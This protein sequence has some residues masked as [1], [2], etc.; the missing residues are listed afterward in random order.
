M[1][2]LAF[3]YFCL[4]LVADPCE[5][6]AG[7]TLVQLDGFTMGTTWRVLYEDSAGRNF[8]S[9]I[10]SLFILLNRSFSTYD[11]ASE[12]SAFNRSD[13]SF[14]FRTPF[15]R[16]L[17]ERSKAIYEASAG[18][19]DPTVM[20]LVRAWGFGPDRLSPMRAPNVDSLLEFVGFD[21]ISF[22]SRQA[23]KRD[24]RVQLDFGGIGQGFAVDV[25]VKF[26]RSKG[27]TDM[28]VELGGEGV[29]MGRNISANRPWHVGVL[30]PRSTR[31]DQHVR[32]YLALGGKAFTTSGNYFNYRDVGGKRVGHTMDPKTGFPVQDR[33]LSVF[34]VA[35]DCTTA[36]AWATAMMASGLERS[37]VLLRNFRHLQGILFFSDDNG[38]V[39]TYI[40]AEIQRMIIAE[41]DYQK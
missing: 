30:D 15:M 19:F 28:L 27:V 14:V 4:L 39:K 6:H 24:P 13:Q 12:V 3:V 38:D 8:Q 40:S 25:V 26:L 22:D 7:K 41:E 31:E 29:A 23:S 34:L 5:S 37:M 36:D 1:P 9:S 11:S 32:Y 16:E 33:L 35:D 18:A 17:L 21:K 20:P 2:L 10:D